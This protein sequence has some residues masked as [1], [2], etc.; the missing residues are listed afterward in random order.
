M[1]VE[2]G[3]VVG[4]GARRDPFDGQQASH[5]A[6]L[7]GLDGRR[8]QAVHLIPEVLAGQGLSGHAPP[9]GQAGLGRPLGDGALGAGV[10]QA[11]DGGGHQGLAHAEAVAMAELAAA[12]TRA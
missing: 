7:D 10:D 9:L 1:R 6:L 11:G 5:D 12:A 2:V 4:D 8:R 3:T